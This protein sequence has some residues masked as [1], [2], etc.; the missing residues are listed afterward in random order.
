MISFYHLRRF[1]IT[2]TLSIMLAITIAFDFGHADSWAM[3]LS[4]QI[5]SQPQ[6]QIANLNRIE[7]FNKNLEGKAQETIGNITGNSKDQIVGK[8]KQVESQVR[9]S[10]EDLKDKAKLQG[11][12]KAVAKNLEGKAQETKG[13]ITGNR[14]DQLAGQSKQ[15]EGQTRNIVEDVKSKVQ[16]LFN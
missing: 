9:N 16:D 6:T 3:S 14:T 2:M 15:V 10:A 11:R 1:F 7:N 5:N 13:Q 4:P 12:A 8:A